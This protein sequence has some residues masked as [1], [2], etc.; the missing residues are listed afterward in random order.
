MHLVLA[1]AGHAHLEVLRHFARSPPDA[2]PAR[3]TLVTPEAT[4]IYSGAVPGVVAGLLPPTAAEIPLAPLLSDAGAEWI[5]DRVTGLDAGRRLL[6]LGRNPPLPYD[7]LS[8]DTGALPVTPPG[9]VPVR[10]WRGLFAA[11]AALD[12]AAGRVAVIGA[13]AAG[14][15]L[16]L[17]LARRPGPR[18]LLLEAMPDVLPGL[19]APFR[20]RAE[21]ALRLAGVS[22][23]TDFPVERLDDGALHGP[24]SRMGQVALAIACTGTRPALDLRD[25]GLACDAAG[26]PRMDAALR[27]QSHHDVFGAGDGV[28]AGLPKAGVWAVRAGPVLADNLSRALLGEPLRPWEPQRQA[29]ILLGT[30][31]GE[32]IG[33]WRGISFEGAWAWRWKRWLDG[34]FV[35]RYAGTGEG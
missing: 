26:F 16:A 21:R 20:A 14:T 28:A 35:R 31:R 10:P 9:T 33:L 4:A 24:E 3:L 17:A 27:S 34:R 29:L 25:S 19:P 15:E 23:R 11:L 6:R 1:G 7:L 30:G 32:A 5:E 8:L 18:P 2:G 13:G 22:W 12:P